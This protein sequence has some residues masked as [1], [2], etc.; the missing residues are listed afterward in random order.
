MGRFMENGYPVGSKI[1]TKNVETIKEIFRD[2]EGVV[3]YPLKDY[4]DIGYGYGYFVLLEDQTRQLFID[5]FLVK[6]VS[7]STPMQNW[8][9]NKC[10][11]LLEIDPMIA[12]QLAEEKAAGDFP[13]GEVK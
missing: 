6:F 12:N 3:T 1:R 8:S 9:R 2:K 4:T 13:Y 11:L 10:L 7:Y 5:D